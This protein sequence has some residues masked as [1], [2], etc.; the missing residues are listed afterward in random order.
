M[1]DRFVVVGAAG[2][3]A[4]FH[5]NSGDSQLFY[6]ITGPAKPSGAFVRIYP[7]FQGLPGLAGRFYPASNAVCWDEPNR[8]GFRGPC[9]TAHQAVQ[10][11][12]RRVVTPRLH[13]V[14]V[15]EQVTQWGVAIRMP[16]VATA[17]ELAFERGWT[18]A[19]PF[20][21]VAH[22][23]EV[24][25]RGPRASVRPKTVFLTPHGVWARG[26]MHLLSRAVYR[27]AALNL[28]R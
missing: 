13:D 28:G 8:R 11:R 2:S 16:N 24:R 9:Q 17:I 25:W 7:M 10:G 20:P 19:A 26:R 22:Q 12:L 5:T 18:R 23:L 1:P 6:W 4:S 21:R 27:F 14:T 15:A 3:S